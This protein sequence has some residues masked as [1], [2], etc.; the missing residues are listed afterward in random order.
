M[1]YTYINLLYS[2]L[3]S[4]LSLTPLDFYYLFLP[5]F[6]NNAKGNHTY[7]E[8]PKCEENS[9]CNLRIRAN[10]YLISL[11]KLCRYEVQPKILLGVQSYDLQLKNCYHGLMFLNKQCASTLGP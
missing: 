6:D 10:V 4:P 3:F 9:E 11:A 7:I 1:V 2:P 5:L 8:T